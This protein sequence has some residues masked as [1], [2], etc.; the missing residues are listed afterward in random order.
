M[1]CQLRAMRAANDSCVCVQVTKFRW[2]LPVHLQSLQA[3]AGSD[4]HQ[5]LYTV[6]VRDH[7]PD[8]VFAEPREVVTIR[9]RLPNNL[10][11]THWVEDAVVTQPNAT[12]DV[13]NC[14]H[15][16]H[17][18][19]CEHVTAVRVH[20]DGFC[21]ELGIDDVDDL[22]AAEVGVSSCIEFNA[23]SHSYRSHFCLH[24][25]A[26]DAYDDMRERQLAQTED[27]INDDVDPCLRPCASPQDSFPYPASPEI[28]THMRHLMLHG[29]PLELRLPMPAGLCQCGCQY[30]YVVAN[31]ACDVYCTEPHLGCKLRLSRLQCALNNPACIVYDGTEDGLFRFS[32][33]SCMALRILYSYADQYTQD[34]KPVS[35]FVRDRN[36]DYER[37]VP[38]GYSSNRGITFASP[39]LF[40]QVYYAW[41]SRLELCYLF[42]CPLCGD[43]PE[44]LIG[45]ATSESIQGK[46]FSGVPITEVPE[47]P[48]TAPRA[49]M[50]TDRRL[51]KSAASRKK[52]A[53]FAG[54]IVGSTTSCITDTDSAEWTSLLE[55]A[56]PVHMAA[57]LTDINE[58]ACELVVHHPMR[59]SVMLKSMASD[60]PVLSYLPNA[61]AELI[62]SGMPSIT[63][64]AP[65][66]L[67][68][69]K[70]KAPHFLDFC[71]AIDTMQG[72][73]TLGLALQHD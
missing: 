17:R 6:Y 47:D 66:L 13:L 71:T 20:L 51:F 4:A 23:A 15:Y 21:P 25:Q 35:S 43:N 59:L 53:A 26:Q 2:Q 44:V 54:T 9:S 24:V 33:H 31:E 60:S 49:H 40:R 42:K 45:D 48:V 56:E 28:V 69:L 10:P 16:S 3:L 57:L 8:A 62:L 73:D 22:N 18:S 46:Y 11:V 1:A 34:G 39:T 72:F 37:Y 7:A 38:P 64:F 58:R 70:F 36:C 67:A 32:D 63:T 41:A 5:C 29:P 12:N 27:V 19:R 55:D 50:R 14:S 65:D 30:R 61:A 68:V 52:L